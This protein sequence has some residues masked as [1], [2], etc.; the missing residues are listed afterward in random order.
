MIFGHFKSGK[1]V[2]LSCSKSILKIEKIWENF[3]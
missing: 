1:K 2:F 3:V